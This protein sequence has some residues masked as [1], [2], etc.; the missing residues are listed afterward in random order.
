[1]KVIIEIHLLVARM[2]NGHAQRYFQLIFNYCGKKISA[3]QSQLA[4][5]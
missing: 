5:I 4:I 3:L 2:M 1:M